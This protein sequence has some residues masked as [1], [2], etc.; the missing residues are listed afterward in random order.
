MLASYKELDYEEHATIIRKKNISVM[1]S[2]FREWRISRVKEHIAIM[3][4]LNEKVSMQNNLTNNNVPKSIESL[5]K[6]DRREYST[7]LLDVLIFQQKD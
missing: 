7:E 4:I 3:Q 6:D 5:G 1:R 2:W